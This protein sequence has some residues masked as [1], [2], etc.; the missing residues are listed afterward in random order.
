[1]KIG[2]NEYQT[3]WAKICREIV[4]LVKKRLNLFMLESAQSYW[5]KVDIDLQNL[6]KVDEKKSKTYLLW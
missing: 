1:M 4:R 6:M 3:Y 5:K 2:G